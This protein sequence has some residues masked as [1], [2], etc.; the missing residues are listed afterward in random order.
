M[1]IN[2]EAA[3]RRICWEGEHCAVFHGVYGR[4]VGEGFRRFSTSKYAQTGART[5]VNTPS[6]ID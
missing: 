3:I 2:N 6:G 4:T 1:S 5:T